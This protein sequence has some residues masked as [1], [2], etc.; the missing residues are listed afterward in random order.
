[1]LLGLPPKLLDSELQLLYL[2]VFE[3]DRFLELKDLFRVSAF[4]VVDFPLQLSHP[5]QVFDLL[6]VDQCHLL[7][8]LHLPGHGRLFRV[9]G[10]LRVGLVLQKHF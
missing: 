9:G 2:V 1:M 10:I 8:Q 3:E 6:L 7:D 4:D 5:F